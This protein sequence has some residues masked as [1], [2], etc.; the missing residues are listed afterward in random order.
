MVSLTLADDREYDEPGKIEYTDN[1]ADERTDTMQ[2]YALFKNDAFNL[3][4]GGTVT[5]TLTTKKGVLRPAIPPTAILQD[6][7]GP[8]VWV[9]DEK[10]RAVRRSVA[11]GDVSGDWLFVEKGLKKGERI[12]SDGAHKVHKGMTVEPAPEQ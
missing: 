9:L 4:P 8:Y 6:V 2:V 1:A 10:N 7:Q 11:R 5:V 12:V 3:K